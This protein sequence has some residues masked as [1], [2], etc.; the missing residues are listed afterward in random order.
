MNQSSH[1]EP[2]TR[3]KVLKA[4]EALSYVPSAAARSLAR[5]AS[6]R[7]LIC[8]TS[9]SND[10]DQ[11]LVA[12]VRAGDHHRVQVLPMVL[13]AG[14]ERPANQH[15]LRELLSG[16][17]GAILLPPLGQS[18]WLQQLLGS[19]A[20]PAIAVNGCDSRDFCCVGIDE[21]AAAHE[22]T[23][24]LIE[25]GHRSLAFLD[26]VHADGRNEERRRGFEDAT[27]ARR[28]RLRTWHCHEV[29]ATYREGM[30]ATRRVLAVDPGVTAIFAAED[31]VAAGVCIA[32]QSLGKIVPRD[33]SIVGFGDA[34]IAT[35]TTPELTTVRAPMELM[36]LRAMDLLL[37]GR[38]GRSGQNS[39]VP[40][41][42]VHRH[43]LTLAPPDIAQLPRPVRPSSPPA[44]VSYSD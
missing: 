19:L 5:G 35:R 14:A 34:P 21:Y 22:M 44:R 43:S 20:V 3:A 10:V 13:P 32:A 24:E 11:A 18:R 41:Q 29:M 26:V 33:L 38:P 40:H 6:A 42:L 31:V 37:A 12:A 28:G 9:Q 25:L 8:C 7:V 27:R 39:C 23:S 4:V 30:L 1:V 16:A 15:Q 36:A 17:A 2:D